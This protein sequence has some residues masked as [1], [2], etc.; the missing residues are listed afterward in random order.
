MSKP[1]TIKST[2]EDL[3]SKKLSVVELTQEKFKLIKDRDSD[4]NSFITLNEDVALKTAKKLDQHLTKN[5]PDTAL[6]GIPIA[7]KDIFLTRGL[8]T[9]AA[10]KLLAD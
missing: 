2:I 4:L 1:R 10:A 3:K 6:F 8:R 5:E 9:T 7:H